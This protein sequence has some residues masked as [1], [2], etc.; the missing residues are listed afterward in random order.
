MYKNIK[1][2]VKFA[3][4]TSDFF[5]IL[6]GVRQGENLS[7]L[8][9]CLFLNDLED[10]LQANDCSGI[11]FNVQHGDILTYLK[12]LIL[13]YADDTVIFATD[14]TSFQRNLNIFF[15]YTRMWRLSINYSKT[16]VMIFGFR[17]VNNF[18]FRLDGNILA[19]TDCFKYLGVYFSKARTFY[20]ARKHSYDQARKAMHLLLKRVCTFNLPLDLQL[21]V[22]DHTVVPILLYGS[23]VW[24]FENTDIIEKLHNEFLRKITHLRKS[25]PIYML[26]AELGRYTLTINIKLRMLN[27]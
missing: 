27:Y 18:S 26:Q 4:K 21:K 14:P 8:L 19:I 17:N 15:E 9:F 24:G 12:A 13:L 22:F 20:K 6:H 5:Y 16:K 2:C 11:N 25:K 23:E 10:F 3:N 1:S 7:P